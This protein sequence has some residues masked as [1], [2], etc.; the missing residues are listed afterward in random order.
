MGVT[1][2]VG[3][4]G[5]GGVLSGFGGVRE[6]FVKDNIQRDKYGMKKRILKFVDFNSLWETK[7]GIFPRAW[8]KF[9]TISQ[10]CKGK[11]KVAKHFEV[12]IS[13]RES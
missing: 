9:E 11:S 8:S 13:G 10:L 3:G 2:R 6:F 7:Q 1:W 12:I 5:G 4:G